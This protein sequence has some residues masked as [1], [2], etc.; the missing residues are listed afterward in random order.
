LISV[1]ENNKKNIII[2]YYY[3]IILS[4]GKLRK[5]PHLHFCANPWTALLKVYTLDALTFVGFVLPSQWSF[6]C[7]T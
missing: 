7:I 3:K 2:K 6:L 1:R 5:I 4:M